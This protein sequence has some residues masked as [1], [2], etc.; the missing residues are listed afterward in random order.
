MSLDL[1]GEP[2]TV[3][4]SRTCTLVLTEPNASKEHLRIAWEDGSWVMTWATNSANGAIP[5]LAATRPINC[6][7]CTS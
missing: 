2:V 1:N 5:V 3:G 7:R 4:R 6:A